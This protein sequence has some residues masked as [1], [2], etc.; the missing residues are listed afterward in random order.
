MFAGARP[1]P[2]P[3]FRL[4]STLIPKH[5][6]DI[7][8]T[9]ADESHSWTDNQHVDAGLPSEPWVI[10]HPSKGETCIDV[11]LEQLAWAR[12]GDKGDKA[13]IGVMARRP[14]YLPFIAEVLN[15]GLYARS[16]RPFFNRRSSRSALFARTQ[17]AQFLC[18]TTR[19]AAE[20]WRA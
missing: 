1:K 3:V 18:F 6:V 4:F 14:D 16:L 11:P 19:L 7:R 15:H 10:P 13:N 17:C 8:I 2:S 12:S 9:T 5:V 20:A